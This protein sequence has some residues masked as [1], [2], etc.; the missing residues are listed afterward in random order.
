MGA[1]GWFTRNVKWLSCGID[2]A[3]YQVHTYLARYLDGLVTS[4][5]KTGYNPLDI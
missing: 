5:E 1:H 2:S 4:G 3:P